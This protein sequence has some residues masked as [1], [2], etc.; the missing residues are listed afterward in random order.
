MYSLRDYVTENNVT[1][2]R[3]VRIGENGLS[4]NAILVLRC[5]QESENALPP[6]DES[7]LVEEQKSGRDK[8]TCCCCTM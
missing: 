1:S 4:K 7:A 2:I 5:L 8:N 3:R 6:H